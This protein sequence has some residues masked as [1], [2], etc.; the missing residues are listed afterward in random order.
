MSCDD[1]AVDERTS[2]G[3]GGRAPERGS[4][5]IAE[6]LRIWRGLA[7]HRRSASARNRLVQ[8]WCHAETLSMAI[9]SPGCREIARSRWRF[10]AKRA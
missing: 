7:E 1:D 4:G 3:G 9:N 8:L 2:I 5:A 6:A 10:G